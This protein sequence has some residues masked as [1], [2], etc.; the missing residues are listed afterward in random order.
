MMY[1]T[2]EDRIMLTT[3]V[4]GDEKKETPI[5]DLFFRYHSLRED[6]IY[7]DM[8]KERHIIRELARAHAMIRVAGRAY[9]SGHDA[10]AERLIQSADE[11]LGQLETTRNYVHGF[12]HMVYPSHS[13]PQ[14]ADEDAAVT[15]CVT[16]TWRSTNSNLRHRGRDSIFTEVGR[17]TIEPDTRPSLYNRVET[18]SLT[19]VV[20]RSGYYFVN[21]LDKYSK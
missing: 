14:S 12:L 7:L 9:Y 21:P 8:H 4:E 19:S 10:L 20:S 17:G 2:L 13:T 6:F 15:E 5:H 18:S 1:E 11:Q 16:K 3:V